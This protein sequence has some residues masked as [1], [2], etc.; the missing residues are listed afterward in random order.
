MHTSSTALVL[1]LVVSVRCGLCADACPLVVNVTGPGKEPVSGVTVELE[2][3]QGAV[4]FRGRSGSSSVKICDFG[5]GRHTL[6]VDRRGCWPTRLEIKGL[7][8][9]LESQLN[10][11][12]NDCPPE[13]W[14]TG[15]LVHMRIRTKEDGR[16]VRD[17]LVTSIP[18]GV[19]RRSD[20]YGRVW[21]L[22]APGATTKLVISAAGFS[23]ESSE[24]RCK[25]TELIELPVT[26]TNRGSSP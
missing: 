20:A 22:V 7:A 14:R 13:Q 9:P 6:V 15:C 1:F 3:S 24:V 12:V 21:P 2:D 5:F 18:S 23:E 10:V 17:A 19:R 11:T 25:S 4:V 16:S 8:G 26:L